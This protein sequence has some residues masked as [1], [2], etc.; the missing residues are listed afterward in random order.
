MKLVR[1][2]RPGQE[3]PGLVDA[4][5][6]LRD[7]SRVV[8]DITPAGL[9]PAALKRLGGANVA[10]LRECLENFPTSFALPE[11]QVTL[12]R[13]AGRA[14]LLASRDLREAMRALDPAWQPAEATIDPTLIDAACPPATPEGATR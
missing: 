5:G 7:L 8:K 2:G 11:A 4:E 9:A 13:R 12:L 10:R 6:T 1:Y 3:K 14:L